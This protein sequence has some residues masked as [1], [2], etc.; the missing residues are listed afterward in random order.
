MIKTE[1]V[2]QWMNFV[3]QT[4]G[5]LQYRVLESFWSSQLKSKQWLIEN[6]NHH[7]I[8]CSGN[9]YIFGGWFGVLGGLII[10]SSEGKSTV[11]SIDVDPTTEL[12]GKQLNPDVNF[13]VNDMQN[14]T[15]NKNPVLIINTST[16]HVTQ[17]VYDKW[18]SKLP[19][20][21]PIILQGNNFFSCP[22]HIRCSTNLEDFNNKNP[23]QKVVYTGELNC[24]QFIRYMTIGY[25]T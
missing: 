20:N 25:K 21:V 17:E 1:R 15:I 8:N 18:F 14:F 22:E 13:I 6:I 10:D 24:V 4:S 3:R 19:N 11:Y 7:Q 9:V 5:E 16:E 12:I 23:L 2:V